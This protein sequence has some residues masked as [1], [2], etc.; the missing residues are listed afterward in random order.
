MQQP[1]DE[2]GYWEKSAEGGDDKNVPASSQAFVAHD[3][4]VSSDSVDTDDDQS[5]FV[6]RDQDAGSLAKQA[7]LPKPSADENVSWEASEFVE[8]DKSATWFLGFGVFAVALIL[9]SVFILKDW[10]M[11]FGSVIM[12]VAIGVVGVRKPRVLRYVLDGTGVHV[13]EQIF[14]YSQFHSFGVV[15]E[16]GLW[17]ILLRPNARF[18]PMLSIYF[19]ERQGEKIVDVLSHFLPM[20]EYRLDAVDRMS[21]KLHF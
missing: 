8:H 5:P 6:S 21:R 15:R 1:A 9:F 3:G 18:R 19:E 20:E 17:S 4:A 10:F 16:G 7:D 2:H 13:G 11:A 12:C 14:K